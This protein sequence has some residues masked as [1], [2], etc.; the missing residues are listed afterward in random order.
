MTVR[1]EL[2]V[3][4]LACAG[5]GLC[6]EIAPELIALDDWGFP[7][8]D[9]GTVPPGLMPAAQAAV[10]SCPVLALRLKP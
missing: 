5:R 3:N 2:R 8:I 6:A 10:R 7:M 4:P 9:V 1:R